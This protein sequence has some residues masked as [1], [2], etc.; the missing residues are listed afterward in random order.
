MRHLD[1]TLVECNLQPGTLNVD[2]VVLEAAPQPAKHK[3]SVGV[4]VSDFLLKSVGVE[5]QA[6]LSQEGP[7]DARVRPFELRRAG[8]IRAHDN[9]SLLQMVLQYIG[10]RSCII[11]HIRHEIA[12]TA[13][14]YPVT[15]RSVTRNGS[16]NDSILELDI[17]VFA[18]RSRQGFSVVVPLSSAEVLEPALPEDWA[19][20]ISA[21]VRASFGTQLNALA[22][23]QTINDRLEG[24]S[25]RNSLVDAISA[26]EAEADQ[27][28]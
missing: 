15:T 11:R 27:A 23:S 13:L 1:D 3:R 22:L 18:L 21:S 16:H 25:G 24:G 2:K 20:G 26:A 6:I 17:D 8:E 12:L 10:A 5:L 28:F 7:K 14:R 9:S 4:Q 19:K